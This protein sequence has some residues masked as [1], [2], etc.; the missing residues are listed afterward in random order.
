MSPHAKNPRAQSAFY[1]LPSYTVSRHNIA[2]NRALGLPS[3]YGRY[4][5]IGTE[6][7]FQHHR[8]ED[9]NRIKPTACIQQDASVPCC[10]AGQKIIL[11][12][13]L[14]YTAGEY[15]E[16]EWNAFCC[17][18]AHRDDM[19]QSVHAEAPNVAEYLPTTQCTQEELPTEDANFPGVHATQPGR[20]LRYAHKNTGHGS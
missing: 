17:I 9:R 13:C 7:T 16:Q 11:E 20:T 14:N 18:A 4:E 15:S 8:T 1:L 6:C 12:V 10:A 5:R 3:A 2:V 19:G